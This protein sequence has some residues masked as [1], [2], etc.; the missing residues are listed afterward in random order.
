MW[1]GRWSRGLLATFLSIGGVAT[2]AQAPQLAA[3]G[4]VTPGQW[5][6]K[7]ADGATRS[8][9]VADPRVLLQIEHGAALCS[10]FVVANDARSA[11]VHYTCPG[12]G[13]GRTT[14]TVDGGQR[15]R[16]QTQGIHD[17]APF[18]TDYEGRRLGNCSAGSGE[19]S[20]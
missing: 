15:F 8:L 1:I 2:A 14:I 6:L 9:C 3:L 20:R 4:A 13:H 11:T 12:A 10:R 17:G 19:R 7:D 5:Q 18:D 16:L